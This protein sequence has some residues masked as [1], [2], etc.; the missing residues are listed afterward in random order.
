MMILIIIII[1]IIIIIT[2]MMIMM[3]IIIIVIIIIVII[4][5]MMIIIIIVIKLKGANRDFFFKTI[6]SLR[7]ELSPT[8]TL[9]LPGRDC[10]QI[11]SKTL[12]AYHAHH[13]V[14]HVVGRDSSAIKFDTVEFAFI[15]ALF[16]WLKPLTD[17]REEE[18]G[19]PRE[20][21]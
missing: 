9:K 13:V 11:T 14:C 1:I 16:Y 19:V 17:Q 21:P 18:A 7:R 5:T 6:F 20:N 2:M 15:V 10:V 3:M 8:C 12:S 4:I